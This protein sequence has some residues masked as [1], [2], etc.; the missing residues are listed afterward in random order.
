VPPHKH[1]SARRLRTAPRRPD[2][3]PLLRVTAKEQ[4]RTSELT[5]PEQQGLQDAATG[6]PS[7]P[8][9]QH[10]EADI[11]GLSQEWDKR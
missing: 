11:F 8:G 9:H 2:D 10:V 5:Q 6:A 1:A 4:A 3:R 7:A